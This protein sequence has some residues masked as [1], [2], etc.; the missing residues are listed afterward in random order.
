VRVALIAVSSGIPNRAGAPVDPE[1][2]D[3]DAGERVPSTSRAETPWVSS[4]GS[5]GSVTESRIAR[6][7]RISEIG[8]GE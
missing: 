4:D 7:G 5:S 3:D 8:E 1:V 2:F 6:K